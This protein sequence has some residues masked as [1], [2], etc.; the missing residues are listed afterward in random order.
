MCTFRRCCAVHVS[1]QLCTFHKP[2]NNVRVQLY[3]HWAHSNQ[4]KHWGDQTRSP[5]IYI[6]IIYIYTYIR[7]FYYYIVLPRWFPWVFCSVSARSS[8]S[9][10]TAPDTKGLYDRGSSSWEQRHIEWEG[11]GDPLEMWMLT[12]L[13]HSSMCFGNLWKPYGRGW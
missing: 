10:Q 4:Q 5:D 3:T 13:S 8:C 11:A 2:P 9:H 1:Q 12:E 6:Y 7:R